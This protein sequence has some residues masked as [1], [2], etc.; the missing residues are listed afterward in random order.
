MRKQDNYLKFG[1][2]TFFGEKIVNKNAIKDTSYPFKGT[3]LFRDFWG[4]FRPKI[5]DF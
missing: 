4:D 1:D 2:E 3:F 5:R